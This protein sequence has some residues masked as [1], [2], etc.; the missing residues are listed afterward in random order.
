MKRKCLTALVVF[1]SVLLIAA[2]ALAATYY[3]TPGDYKTKR[4]DAGGGVYQSIPFG[5]KVSIVSREGYYWVSYG[6]EVCRVSS[7]KNFS[8]DPPSEE[9]L[10]I[11]GYVKAGQTLEK[12]KETAQ[13]LSGSEVIFSSFN[14]KSVKSGPSVKP[15]FTVGDRDVLVV[16]VRTYHWNRGKGSKPG[17]VSI[18]A[19]DGTL[20]GTW[21]AEG[22]PGSGKKNVN[23]VIYPNV[24]LKAG[25]EYYIADSGEKT[26]SYNSTS[27][28]TG[29]AE[30]R[31]VKQEGTAAEEKTETET[32]GEP[33]SGGWT[34]P[35][36]GHTENTGKF[37]GNCGGAKP[38]SKWT[39]PSCGREGNDENFCPNCGSARP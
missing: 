20:I 38:E 5:A 33:A 17:T 28:G 34:C 9:D 26:W 35:S 31:G 16:S 29:F 36:C 24:M 8:K 25:K 22:Q 30:V 1:L 23:W 19:A 37:C 12:A 14:S 27:G 7:L 18:Y 10:A 6:R 2:V 32:A 3:H 15:A 4:Y 13:K 39:C 11:A 21:D